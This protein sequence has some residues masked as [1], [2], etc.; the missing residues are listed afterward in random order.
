MSGAA[1][2]SVLGLA[3][4]LASPW[5]I[6]PTAM[7]QSTSYCLQDTATLLETSASLRSIFINGSTGSIA[8]ICIDLPGAHLSISPEGNLTLLRRQAGT[9]IEYY[10]SGV[11]RGLLERIGRIDIDYFTSGSRAGKVK[12]VGSIDFDYF[13]IGLR[14]GKVKAVADIE[15]D[16]FTQGS[17]AGRL[18][19]I[20]SV[21]IDYDDGQ[22]DTNG[23]LREADLFIVEDQLAP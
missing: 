1:K 13:T 14:I 6:S 15:I 7:G 17:N 23:S 9:E 22:I 21:S 19:Q 10:S 8:E 12:A 5:V 3:V 11:R 4:A 16:Y 18:R 20:G 2:L